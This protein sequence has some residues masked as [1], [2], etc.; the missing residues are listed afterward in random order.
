M[1]VYVLKLENQK[2]WVGYTSE[3]I[4]RIKQFVG[5]NEWISVNKPISFYKIFSA[6]KYRLDNE[7]K[8]LM[9]EFGIEN[10]RGGSWSNSILPSSVVRELRMEISGDTEK[11]CFLCHKMGHFLQDCPE[12]N[13][14]DSIS[15]FFGST[16]EPS[17]AIRPRPRSLNVSPLPPFSRIN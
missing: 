3:T 4:Q 16:A 6:R 8:E 17:P 2:Y 13:S 7:V 15:E 12:D 14:D 1:S 11:V 9:A 5:L 10:V